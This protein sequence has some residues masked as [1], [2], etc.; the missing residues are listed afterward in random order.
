MKAQALSTSA[1]RVLM[2]APASAPVAGAEPAAV[3]AFAGP[4]QFTQQGIAAQAGQGH[5]KRLPQPAAHVVLT[6]SQ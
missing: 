6:P 3:P 4:P 1:S 2:A 5:Q